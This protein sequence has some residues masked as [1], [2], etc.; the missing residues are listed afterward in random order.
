[1]F[2]W[3]IFCA[4]RLRSLVLLPPERKLTSKS[5]NANVRVRTEISCYNVV[6]VF[7]T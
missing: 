2:F 7:G 1:M 5:F 4:V 6:A 3:S